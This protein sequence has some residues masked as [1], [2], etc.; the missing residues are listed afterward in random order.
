[1]YQGRFE[2]ARPSREPRRRGG[3]GR[4]TMMVLST[5]LLLALAIG[6][7]V[8]WLTTNT[9]GITNTFTPSQVSCEVKEEFNGSVKSNVTVKNTSDIEAYIRVKLITYRVN[10]ENNHI[11]GTAAIPSFNPGEGWVLYNG[12]YYYTK[13][14]A[15]GA[16]ISPALI[17]SITL[18]SSYKDADGGKQAIDVMA[19]AI[20]SEPAKAVG[21]AW[22]VTIAPNS[23]TAYTAGN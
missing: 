2:P 11:G 19:E 17:S 5:L 20:Q 15:S 4:M 18:E 10:D 1:M 14:V 3:K 22:G 8:A 16:S 13:P 23:V 12:Y 6:G 9:E 21:E 7:T